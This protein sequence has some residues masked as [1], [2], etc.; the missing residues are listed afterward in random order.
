MF[1]KAHMS[2]TPIKG[3]QEAEDIACSILQGLQ[4]R[5]HAGFG[6]ILEGLEEEAQEVQKETKDAG[7]YAIA[8]DIRVHGIY[9]GACTR[10]GFVLFMT[11][12]T[13]V[14]RV[15]LLG[16]LAGFIVLRGHRLLHLPI[17]AQG[18]ERFG[19]RLL[20]LG[21]GGD[22]RAGHGAGCGCAAGFT[23]GVFAGSGRV[24]GG[25]RVGVL[26]QIVDVINRVSL[27]DG[28]GFIAIGDRYRIARFEGYFV[29]AL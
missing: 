28:D 7:E 13:L 2:R 19:F 12:G 21:A 20:A 14:D 11:A 10:R 25:V 22:F 16:K 15:T 4:E 9:R 29:A 17:V 6:E 1:E 27:F 24:Y 18:G 5:F 26:D 23:P 3:I 8:G